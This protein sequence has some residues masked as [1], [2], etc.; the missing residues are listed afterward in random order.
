M[1][2]MAPTT[3]S[4]SGGA[5]NSSGRANG[6]EGLTFWLEK[7]IPEATRTSAVNA[8]LPILYDE[9]RELA[10]AYLRRERPNHTLQPTALVHESY[11]RLR[12]QHSVDW[13]DRLQFLS[14][15]ARMMRRILANHAAARA[16]GKRGAG[17]PMLE[18]DSALKVYD[19]ESIS[20]EKVDQA[21]SDLESIDPRQAQIV[22]MR[23][24]GGMTTEEIGEALNTSPRTIHR[25]WTVAKRWLRR[26]LSA[27]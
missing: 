8:A 4:R 16:A 22:E 7:I 1:S 12:E 21:L 5:T 6:A 9:L 23:F 26:E 19:H 3:T 27:A 25:E 24:F 14:I 13:T 15:A 18:L 2:E 10:A 17:A 20:L 11:L